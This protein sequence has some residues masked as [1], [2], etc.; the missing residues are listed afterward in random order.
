M[1]YDLWLERKW[2]VQGI[3]LGIGPTIRTSLKQ[4]HT[5]FVEAKTMDEDTMDIPSVFLVEFS[6]FFSSYLAYCFV[7]LEF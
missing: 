2:I 3:L 1:I 7:F 6:C 5:F 4:F